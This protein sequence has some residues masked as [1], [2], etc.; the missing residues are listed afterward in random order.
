MYTMTSSKFYLS[1]LVFK[2][3]NFYCKHLE[4]KMEKNNCILVM[5]NS[6]STKKAIQILEMPDNYT[7]I[8]VP[9]CKPK[10]GE[11]YLF[12]LPAEKAGTWL[13]IKVDIHSGLKYLRS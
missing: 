7:T 5:N 2:Q 6:L 12:D 8:C 10:A 1:K 13:Y 3:I 4:A 9:P 11:A